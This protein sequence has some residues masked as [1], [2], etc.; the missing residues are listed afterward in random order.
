M[1]HTFDVSF[2]FIGGIF[3]MPPRVFI[4]LSYLNIYHVVNIMQT[5][6]YVTRPG[7]TVTLYDCSFLGKYKSQRPDIL[8]QSSFESLICAINILNYYLW[9]HGNYALFGNGNFEFWWLH[10]K[11]LVQI[12]QNI[13]YFKLEKYVCN[14]RN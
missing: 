4:M 1:M 10:R 14:Y 6:Y 11:D 5:C 9:Y 8:T 3:D 13:P 12:Y 2:Q 7:S